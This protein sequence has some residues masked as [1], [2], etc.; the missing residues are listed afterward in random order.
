MKKNAFE[1]L[2]GYRVDE[3]VFAGAKPYAVFEDD[4]ERMHC[5]LT[6]MQITDLIDLREGSEKLEVC[7]GC[8]TVHEFAIRDNGVPDIV[9]LDKIVEKIFTLTNE[10]KKIYI[11]CN[12]GLGRTGIVVCGYL[13]KH[14][15]ASSK[16]ALEMLKTLKS[17]SVLAN[18]H[19]PITKLQ[20]GF[21]RYSTIHPT[22][23][24]SWRG[25]FIQ[26]QS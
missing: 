20:V 2:P 23:E 8:F 17:F 26:T 15:G 16:E 14:H 11:H 22:R 1:F 21:I 9:L 12:Q 6:G 7:K 5:E 3:N 24:T 10:G 25:P 19:S 13:I 4:Q 18:Y